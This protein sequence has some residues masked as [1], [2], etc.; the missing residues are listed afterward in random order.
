MSYASKQQL[1]YEKYDLHSSRYPQL[2]S[3]ITFG[4][5]YFAF[6]KVHEGR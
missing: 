5:I 3:L 2:R 1:E 4:S 6:K